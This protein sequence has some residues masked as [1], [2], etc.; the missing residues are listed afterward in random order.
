MTDIKSA[1]SVS[2]TFCS[3]KV[4]SSVV[5]FHDRQPT[6]LMPFLAVV[7]VGV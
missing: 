2:R 1:R 5:S 6:V 3:E 7:F 4:L